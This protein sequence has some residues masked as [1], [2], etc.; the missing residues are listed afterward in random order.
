[1]VAADQR[2]WR[3]RLARREPVLDRPLAPHREGAHRR[4]DALE[5]PRPEIFEV[6]QAADQAPG[7]VW[8]DHATRLGQGLETGGQVRRLAEDRLLVRPAPAD[9]IPPP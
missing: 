2:Q 1:L 5:R 3:A 4:L 8:N 6:E 7:G 9:E